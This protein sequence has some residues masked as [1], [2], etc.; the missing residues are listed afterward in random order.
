[1]KKSP[2]CKPPAK[3][4]RK[5]RK[6]R[7]AAGIIGPAE[8]SKLAQLSRAAYDHQIRLGTISAL[9]TPDTWRREIIAAHYSVPGVSHLPRALWRDAAALFL[10]LAGRDDEALAYLLKTGRVHDG[11]DPTDTHEAREALAHNLRAELAAH[12]L[13]EAPGGHLDPA[14]LLTAARPRSGI[15]KIT[16]ENLHLK[17]SREKLFA[18]LCHLRRHIAIREGRPYTPTSPRLYPPKPDPTAYPL[19][20]R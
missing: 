19:S 7:P 6:P 2:S 15:E 11:G 13:R 17:L 12:A 9:E 20:D 16:L 4:L 14:W 1:M 5:G 8:R 10:R 18:L 3:P